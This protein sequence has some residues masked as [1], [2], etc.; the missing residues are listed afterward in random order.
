MGRLTGKWGAK[1]YEEG[2]PGMPPLLLVAVGGMLGANARFLI[3]NWS[4]ERF[5]RE[6]PHGTLIVNVSGSFLLGLLATLI[7]ERFSGD[8]TASLLLATG[9]LGAY[10][11]FSTFSVET[12]AL[13]QRGR[14]R[15]ALAN[16]LI[17]AGGGIA[18]ALLGISLALIAS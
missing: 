10:T 4:V 14:Y 12:L 11:T 18:G 9:F 16:V 3:A 7:A 2:V 17:S 1:G 15:P 6:F 8:R 13:L 5:G